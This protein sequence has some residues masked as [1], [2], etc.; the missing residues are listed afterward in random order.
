MLVL[1]TMLISVSNNLPKTAYIKMIDVWL[2]SSLIKP[3]LDIM[4]QTYINY[5][6]DDSSREINHHGQPRKVEDD[7]TGVNLVQVAPFDQKMELSKLKSVDE[8]IQREALKELYARD[9]GKKRT[10]KIA[11]MRKISTKLNPAA[12]C[13]F[14][15]VYWTIGMRQYYAQV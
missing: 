14:V 10:N 12:C 5:L 9:V 1:T 3:F 6:R 13:V 2:L 4:L 8:K 11:K 15:L 7:N